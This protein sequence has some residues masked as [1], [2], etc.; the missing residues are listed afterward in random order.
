MSGDCSAKAGSVS[1]PAIVS[2]IRRPYR[3]VPIGR[4]RS[5]MNANTSSSGSAQ[6]KLPCSS[7]VYPSSDA[8]AE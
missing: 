4:S 2:Y 7:A 8:I 5:L 3:Y 6:S 1:Q